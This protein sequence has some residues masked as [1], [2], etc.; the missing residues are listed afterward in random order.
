MLLSLLRIHLRPH[1]RSVALLVLL[2]LVQVLATL[3][4][5]TLGAAIIDKGVVRSDS[6]YITRTGLTML[7]VA[8]LQIATSVGAVSLSARTA[9]ALGRDLRSAVFRRVLDF[10]AREVGQLG[11]PSLM[12]RTV[13]DV[14]QV[15]MLA[16]SAFGVAVAA[17]LMCLGSIALALQQDV[18]LSLVLVA[19]VVVL[20]LAFGLILGRTDRF[21]ARMQKY[22]DRTNGLLRERITGVRVVRAFVRDDHEGERFSRVNSELH[23]ISL[24]VG[25]LLA[26][27]IPV[28]LFALN[29]FMVAVL[30][31]GAHRVASGEVPFGALS[32]FLS[33]LSLVLMAVVMVTFVC[34]ALP[35][36]RVSAERIQQ[37]LTTEPSVAAPPDPVRVAPTAGALE[38]C[39]AEF[40]YPGAKDPV[41]SGIDLR[42][43]PGETV[44]ILGSTGSGKTTLLNLVLRHFDV[45]AGSVNV[46]GVDVR[47]LDGEVLRR[48]VGFVPQRPYLFSGTVAG[49]L[50]FGVPDATD[51]ELW[52]VLEIA[53][54]RDFVQR[55]PGGLNAPI[56]QGGTNVSGGQRQRLSIARTLLRKPDIYLF[57]DCFSALDY[58]TDAALRAALEPEL[59]RA[60]VLTVAQR[61]STVQHARRIV[62][63]DAGRMVATG[64][65]DELLRTSATY[66][67]IA[68]SQLTTSNGHHGGSGPDAGTT[69]TPQEAVHGLGGPR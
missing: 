46:G 50:R 57:D 63:L 36:A 49:N 12:T 40:R 54:A 17:P 31:F 21:Y 29:A 22:L 69:T 16:L 10:S 30:W 8:L 47:A 11:T 53:Q 20:G 38:L 43:G 7:A 65:H 14:Q 18:G 1:R 2:Q 52:R 3:A 6:G 27:I 25:R 45:T 24:H 19:L 28:V 23:G 41:L 48:T 66:Q 5:P 42:T 4:L 13:N 39:G 37:V 62:V 32:A 44:A 61:V 26:A 35:R 68:R 59:S 64:T 55:L 34:L 15:Q 60:T 58:A 67:E 33:Y 9:M 56:T 51:E